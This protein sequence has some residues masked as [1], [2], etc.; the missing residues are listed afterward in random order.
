MEAKML[1]VTRLAGVSLILLMAACDAPDET[2]QALA[3]D[4][5]GFV[6]QTAIIDGSTVVKSFF[7]FTPPVVAGPLPT[8]KNDV[9]LYPTLEICELSAN[10]CGLVLWQF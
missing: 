2:D 1:R 4:A 7:R 6:N 9:D 8:G 5:S 3:V 10:S